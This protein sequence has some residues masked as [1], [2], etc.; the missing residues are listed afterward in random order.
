[1]ILTSSPAQEFERLWALAADPNPFHDSGRHVRLRVAYEDTGQT[2][3]VVL[4][5]AWKFGAMYR[6]RQDVTTP[7]PDTTDWAI[8]DNGVAWTWS[9]AQS[10]HNNLS[11]FRPGLSAPKGMDFTVM[12]GQHWSQLCA[13]QTQGLS[14]IRNWPKTPEFRADANG[15]FLA[16]SAIPDAELRIEGT[17]NP[18]RISSITHSGTATKGPFRLVVTC[19][20][21]DETLNSLDYNLPGVFRRR[22]TL[23]EDE[24]TTRSVVRDVVRLPLDREVD[25]IRG[26]VSIARVNDSRGDTRVQ[27]TFRD[28]EK[29]VQLQSPSGSNLL[30]KVTRYGLATAA[31][32]VIILVLIRLFLKRRTT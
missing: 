29:A 16:V 12:Q 9:N 32:A 18:L 17:T 5:E 21:Q 22:Y 28:G 19:K 20:W 24:P 30:T 10:D 4:F 13:F 8:D 2:P 15:G 1:M 11:V 23:E 27:Y 14:L 6:I 26:K 3:H 31:S 25:P 7:K